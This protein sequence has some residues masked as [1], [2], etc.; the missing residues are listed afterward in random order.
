M[1]FSTSVAL[2][3]QKNYLYTDLQVKERISAA[4][5][6]VLLV[7]TFHFVN[8]DLYNIKHLILYCY[9]YVLCNIKG[10]KG[11]NKSGNGEG[12]KVG[13]PDYGNDNRQ[14]FLP[15]A[16]RLYYLYFWLL[17]DRENIW[18]DIHQ[19]FDKF[20][21]TMTQVLTTSRKRK[22]VKDSP[23]MSQELVNR[24]QGI[25]VLKYKQMCL[26]SQISERHKLVIQR[27]TQD[28]NIDEIR[29]LL[30]DYDP[31]SAKGKLYS[32]MI[33]KYDHR[34]TETK[35]LLEKVEHEISMINQDIEVIEEREIVDG[36]TPV[37]QK[38]NV[39]VKINS[40]SILHHEEFDDEYVLGIF[41][42]KYS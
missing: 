34:L 7:S 15:K 10:R 23:D 41:N 16:G 11:W 8:Y 4:R 13:E 27:D 18:D 3:I 42:V 26:K 19:K 30:L 29:I 17:T 35:T 24:W 37:K 28:S 22:H 32:E 6:S 5:S 20:S 36:V 25:S 9:K 40:F 1:E 31:S 21:T 39:S 14:D 33:T 12:N 2:R 38:K